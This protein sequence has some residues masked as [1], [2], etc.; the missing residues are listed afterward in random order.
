[1]PA[2]VDLAEVDALVTELTTAGISASIDP[3]EVDP[4]GVWVRHVGLSLDL[5][6]GFTIKTQLHLVVPDN[7]HAE[8]RTGLVDLLNQVLA[9]AEPDE[10][11]YFQGL[12]LPHHPKPLPGLVLPL[13]LTDTYQE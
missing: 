13:N 12:V 1:M 4:P 9:V 6:G 10:D 5:L 3:A 2:Q 7:G 8:A 11:P